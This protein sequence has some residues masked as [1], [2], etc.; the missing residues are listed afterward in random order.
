MKSILLL[1]AL[2]ASP[3][4]F[5][6]TN[7]T[8]PFYAGIDLH[9][10]DASHACFL[11]TFGSQRLEIPLALTD[12]SY[13]YYTGRA[14][15]EREENGKTYEGKI[16]VEMWKGTPQNRISL[17]IGE[18]GKPETATHLSFWVQNLHDFVHFELE[19]SPAPVKD[20]T[21]SATLSFGPEYQSAH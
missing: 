5:G 3:L 18:K 17:E 9:V 2:A 4:A 10:C 7:E 16:F 12:S 6:A 19:A 21:Q 8:M 1:L 11:S 13:R 14:S 20:G 15:V